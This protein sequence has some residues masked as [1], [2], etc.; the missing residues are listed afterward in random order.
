MEHVRILT[1]VTNVSAILDFTGR[2][3]TKKGFCTVKQKGTDQIQYTTSLLATPQI[4]RTMDRWSRTNKSLRKGLVI[5]HE[6]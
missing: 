6:I 3:V 4:L 2:D 1:R 5:S